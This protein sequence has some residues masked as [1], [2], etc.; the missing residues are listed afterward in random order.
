[1]FEEEGEPGARPEQTLMERRGALDS[2]GPVQEK[3]GG[4]REL[5]MEWMW[6]LKGRAGPWETPARDW[7]EPRMDD[8]AIF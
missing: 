7:T 4:K 3:C 2:G 1:M 8:A 6:A 5:A